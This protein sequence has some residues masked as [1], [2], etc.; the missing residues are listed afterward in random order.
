MVDRV[1]GGRYRLLKVL[2]RGAFG[3]TYLSQDLEDPKQPRC[4]VKELKPQAT[5]E[6]TL[7]EAKRLFAI[8]A[9]V[10]ERLG[11]HPQIPALLRYYEEEFYLV[12]EFVDGHDLTKEIRSG[13]PLSEAK[14]QA[15][16]FEI[17]PTL[18]FI[19]QKNVIHRDLK[20]SNLR[21]ARDG[22]VVLIDFGAVKEVKTMMLAANGQPKPS[23]VAGTQGYMPP[24]QLRGR[25]RPNSDIYALGLIV[26]QALTGRAPIQL[27]E[28]PQTGELIWRD[29]V[30]EIAEPFAD[31]IE[32]MICP[33]YTQRYQTVAEVLDDLNAIVHTK[34]KKLKPWRRTTIVAGQ[35]TGG[36]W[37]WGLLGGA[38]VLGL[39]TVFAWPH[40]RA[41]L[42]YREGNRLLGENEFEGAIA[43]YDRVLEQWPNSPPTLQLKGYAASQL[44]RFQDQYNACNRALEIDPEFVQALNCRGLALRR[45]GD[46]EAAISDFEAIINLDPDFFQAWNN[47]GEALL[48]SKDPEGALAAFDKAIL[49]KKDYVFAWNNRGNALLQLERFAEAEVAYEEAIRLDPSYPYAWNG[50]GVARRKLRRP[51]AALEDF[52]AATDLAPS[53]FFEAWFNRGQA[54]VEIDPPRP[55]EAIEAFS[56]AIEI[57]RDYQA[58]ITQR[59]SVRQRFGL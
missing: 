1:V 55:E 5:D 45:L 35:K 56:R 18:G 36:F 12:Q 21:R 16:L 22:R 49:Y 30:A 54:L 47:L 4:V 20:P 6:L 26:V 38:L 40:G 58:A 9:Q 33:D 46:V 25:P 53:I 27:A 42:A 13:E 37:R 44:G 31:L 17:L 28:D 19:H 10:L 51:A 41:M 52:I 15:I 59:E 34:V 32:R 39:G 29:Y 2:G 14:V 11:H 8:E 23:I 50:R 48:Q 7:R 24:E 57:R 43:A 3:Q